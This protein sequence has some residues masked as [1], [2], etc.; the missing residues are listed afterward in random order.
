MKT[1]TCFK[2]GFSVAMLVLLGGAVMHPMLAAPAAP[3]LAADAPVVSVA[4]AATA[5]SNADWEPPIG[6]PWPEFG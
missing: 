3:V 1:Q 6:I 2:K 5:T 4:A